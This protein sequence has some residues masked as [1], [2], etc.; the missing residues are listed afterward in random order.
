[1]LGDTKGDT[2]LDTATVW[3]SKNY[4]KNNSAVDSVMKK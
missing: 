2:G 1:M 3:H 4:A